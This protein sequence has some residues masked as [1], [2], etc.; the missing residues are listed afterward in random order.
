MKLYPLPLALVASTRRSISLS[1]SALSPIA[2]P[3][4]TNSVICL[5][6]CYFISIRYVFNAV[7][8]LAACA[9]P[10]SS[11]RTLSVRV[12]EMRQ[13]LLL[14][15][16]SPPP[17]AEQSPMFPLPWAILA[18]W[19]NVEIHQFQDNHRGHR[20]TLQSHYYDGRRKNMLNTSGDIS[21]PCRRPWQT[22]NHVEKSPSS[23]GTRAGIPSWNVGKILISKAELQNGHV[24]PIVA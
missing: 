3:G 16:T 11:A 10:L 7:L 6:R 21:H 13:R 17:L 4:Y 19:Q 22:L 5:Y 23:S 14:H 2:S 18:L 15:T 24:L 9:W 12:P 8:D 1:R 20:E